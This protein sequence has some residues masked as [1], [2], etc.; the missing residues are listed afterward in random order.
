MQPPVRP[1]AAF[2]NI[3]F[4]FDLFARR[5]GILFRKLLTNFVDYCSVSPI[6]QRAQQPSGESA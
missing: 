6:A 2:W 4:S 1:A 5:R 3:F